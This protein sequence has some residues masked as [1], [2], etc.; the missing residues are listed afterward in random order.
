MSHTPTTNASTG[1]TTRGGDEG[2]G[3]P[4]ALAGGST[5]NGDP[6]NMSSTSSDAA[7]APGRTGD[8]DVERQKEQSINIREQKEQKEQKEKEQM[9]KEREEAEQALQKKEKGW[10]GNGKDGTPNKFK[11]PVKDDGSASASGNP[12]GKSV[13]TSVS[14]TPMKTYPLVGGNKRL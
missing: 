13:G 2:Q 6:S 5:S 8:P 11:T 1:T 12:S 9:E 3:A 10:L 14:N 7:A 4:L